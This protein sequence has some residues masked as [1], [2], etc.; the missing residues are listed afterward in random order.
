MA[1]HAMVNVHVD[2]TKG[3]AGGGVCMLPLSVPG[4]SRGKPLEK[5]GVRDLPQ[6]ELFF[7][8][9]RIPK[10]W[11][12]AQPEG[13]GDWVINNL[14]FGNT[15]VAVLTVGIAQAGFEETLAYT[16]ERV[17]GG[18]PLIEHYSMKVR[19]HRLFAKVEA[20]RAFSRAVWIANARVYP[21]LSEYAYASK[22]FCSE[23]AKEVIDEGVQI[24]GANGLTK[25]YFIE[26][27]WR[28]VRPM[29]IADGENTTLNCMGGN[30]LKD[31]YPRTSAN[32]IA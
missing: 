10:Q 7:D 30:I 12:F 17:Q 29:T 8:N 19:L 28:D 13:Y 27:L 24:H 16:K 3:M 20:I 26:K 4:V 31:T 32:V 25:E 2:T 23:M 9:A 1:T 15:A 14:G 5:L 22:T 21:P 6:G 11:M 18:K